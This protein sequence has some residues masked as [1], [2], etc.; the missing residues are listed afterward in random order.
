MGVAWVLTTPTIL[1]MAAF[2]KEI[3]SFSPKSSLKQVP[4]HITTN[5]GK[6]FLETREADGETKLVQQEGRSLGFCPDLRPDKDIGVALPRLFIASQDVA[7]DNSALSALGVTHILNVAADLPNAF[8]SEYVY[9]SVPMY[10][11]E[12]EI[13]MRHYSK[14]QD[15][16]D[17]ALSKEDGR[18]LVHCRA[19]RSRSVSVVVAY[20]MHKDKSLSVEKALEKIRETR[21]NAD[22]NSGFVKQLKALETELQGTA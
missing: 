19:G 8:P 10:D 4:T 16:I 11:D 15:F 7:Y 6:R 9:C 17:E 5:D 18:L 1:V 21:P 14:C 13:L 12:D 2:L 3:E 22:P 20:M